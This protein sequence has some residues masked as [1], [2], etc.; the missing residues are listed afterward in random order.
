MTQ[1]KRDARYPD[2]DAL[3]DDFYTAFSDGRYLHKGDLVLFAAAPD[4]AD[5]AGE[6]ATEPEGEKKEK[7]EGSGKERRTPSA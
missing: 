1:D 2:V 4:K 7:A 6:P 5:K 3:L